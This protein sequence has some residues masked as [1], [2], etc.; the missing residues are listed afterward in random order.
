MYQPY[1][2]NTAE[3]WQL[4]ENTTTHSKDRN[5]RCA[6]LYDML[7]LEAQALSLLLRP[8]QLRAYI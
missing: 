2:C 4:I 8:A 6:I 3:A 1:Q 7:L 5:K